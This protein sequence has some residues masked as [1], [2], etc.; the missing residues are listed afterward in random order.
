MYIVEKLNKK[1]AIHH[2]YTDITLLE[3][4]FFCFVPQ[5]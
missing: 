2:Y 1:I 4:K 5:S 3:K